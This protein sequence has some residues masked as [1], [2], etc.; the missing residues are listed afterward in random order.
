MYVSPRHTLTA[1]DSRRLP[2]PAASLDVARWLF[3]LGDDDYRRTSRAHLGAG[4]F[5][6]ADGRRGLFDAE[7]F[8]GVTIVNHHV[9][10][11]ARADYVRVRSRDSRAWLLGLVPVPLEVCWEMAVLA[12]GPARSDLVCRL[13]LGLPRRGLECLARALGVAAV[14]RR[15]VAEQTAGFAAD[16]L[17][18]QGGA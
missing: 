11:E 3:S 5:T 12:A 14:Q 2:V 13:H 17:A 18:K 9:E 15:H 7:A 8:A 4:T 1:S 10:E 6:T 16:I